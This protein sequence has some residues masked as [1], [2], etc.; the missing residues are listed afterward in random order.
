MWRSNSSAWKVWLCLPAKGWWG[1]SQNAKCKQGEGA[2][3]GN[4]PARIQ[5]CSNIPKLPSLVN[6]NIR[7]LLARLHPAH[8]SLECRMRSSTLTNARRS[9]SKSGRAECCERSDLLEF[10]TILYQ[11]L[12]SPAQG[13]PTFGKTSHQRNSWLAAWRLWFW[14]WWL[15]VRKRLPVSSASKPGGI[16]ANDQDNLTF[17]Y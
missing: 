9:D 6:W 10:F 7:E 15:A 13:H 16:P 8:H 2:Q 14:S 4:F 12:K 11:S 5:T 3:S 17:E 1:K